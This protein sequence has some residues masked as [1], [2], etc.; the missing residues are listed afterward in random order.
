VKAV[1]Q[2]R[3]NS[4]NHAAPAIKVSYAQEGDLAKSGLAI[5][6]SPQKDCSTGEQVIDSHRCSEDVYHTQAPW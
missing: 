5:E 4:T 3:E 2:A 1:I 6:S